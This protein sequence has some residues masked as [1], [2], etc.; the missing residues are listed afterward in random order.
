MT[1]V[2]RGTVWLAALT[3]GVSVGI[4]SAQQGTKP[5]AKQ[6]AS[7]KAVIGKP[8]KAFALRDIASDKKTTVDLAAFKGKKVVVGV[9]MAN[10]CGTTWTYEQK[11][12]NLIKDYTPKDVAVVAIH[13]NYNET[14][15]EI[16]GQIEQR[17]LAMPVLD[18]KPTQSLAKYIGARCTPTFF[19]VDKQG[20][21]QYIGA[22]DKYGREPYIAPVLD[23]VLT[24]KKAPYAQT[25]AFG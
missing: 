2:R 15:E 11:I 24:G 1:T 25:M 20:V 3:L 13:A 22:F 4:A 18:D 23:A 9:F 10:R 17:N 19:V 8:F 12:G 7:D 5:A 14:D 21:L 16:M 6:T